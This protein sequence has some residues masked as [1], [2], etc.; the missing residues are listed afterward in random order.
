VLCVV[1]KLTPSS[2]DQTVANG[3]FGAFLSIFPVIGYVVKPEIQT[4]AHFL[5]F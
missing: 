1:V 3:I 2:I 5:P 4:D